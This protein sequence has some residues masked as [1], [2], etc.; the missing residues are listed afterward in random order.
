MALINCPECGKEISDKAD[1][2]IN[3]GF[4]LKE[5]FE[6]KEVCP[7]CGHENIKGE[8]YCESC[9]SRLTEYHVESKNRKVE[10]VEKSKKKENKKTPFWKKTWFTVL[11][12]IF[13]PVIGILLLWVN[14]KPQKI[15]F[16]IL[17]SVIL[18]LYLMFMLGG[19][20]EEPINS[21]STADDILS[22]TETQTSEDNSTEE[23][24]EI[25]RD[26]K[27][28]LEYVTNKEVAEEAYNILTKEIGF[29]ELEFNGKLAGTTN[30]KVEAD[31]YDII[32]TASDDLYRVFI[33]ESSIVF[34]EDNKI[35]MTKKDMEA[36]IIGRA[37]MGP[38]YQMAQEVI[39][40]CLK[41]PNSA[42]FPSIVT[43]PE[44]IA[45]Q[46]NGD[47]I[48]VQSYVDA[49]N[50]FGAEVRSKWTVQYKVVDLK[51]YMY[52]VIFINLDGESSGE[53]ID[54]D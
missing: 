37:E 4:P 28:Q 48:A 10:D 54:M 19:G 32:V 34:Y 36:K 15:K 17:L 12:C 33:P 6:E 44:E 9:A 30:W 20:N 3:C 16:R 50:S 27:S 53:F 49:K 5:Y 14:K 18:F 40:G 31:G 8:D 22:T 29:R 39:R 35:L 52:E 42:D 46:K 2:C 51:S 11:M 1:N 41:N 26:F 25:K 7:Y 45:M 21:A 23:V 43:H 47:I 24:T 13:S 38:Y